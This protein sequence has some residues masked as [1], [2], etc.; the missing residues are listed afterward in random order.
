MTHIQAHFIMLWRQHLESVQE[1]TILHQL[2]IDVMQLGNAHCRRLPHI[3]I[4]ILCTVTLSK[5]F[6]L[7][8]ILQGCI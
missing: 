1:A 6:L 8:L 3:G 5:I 4:I 2:S 7:S